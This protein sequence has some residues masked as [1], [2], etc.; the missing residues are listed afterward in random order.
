MPKEETFANAARKR[1]GAFLVK[2]AGFHKKTLTWYFKLYP[3]ICIEVL[4]ERSRGFTFAFCGIKPAY[5]PDNIGF[6][7]G[8]ITCHGL[9]HIIQDYQKMFFSLLQNNL[10][11][12]YVLD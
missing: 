1:V 10:L 5:V 11:K 7:Y 12:N 8:I 9:T 6:L 4:F 3:E 2:E